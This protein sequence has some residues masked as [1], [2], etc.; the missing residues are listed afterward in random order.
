MWRIR[1]WSRTFEVSQSKRC[2]EAIKWVPIPNKQ[3]GDGYTELMDHPN[4]AAH[5]GAW[6][7]I[8]QL[9]SKCR[10]R[11]TLA[12]DEGHAHDVQSIARITRIRPEVLEESIPRFLK[13]RWLEEVSRSA[14]GEV[15]ECSPSTGQDR[16]GQDITT[17]PAGSPV[18]FSE[19]FNPDAWNHA[20]AMAKA[21][22]NRIWPKRE[23]VLD[24]GDYELVGKAAYLA[25]T[26]LSEAWFM[27]ALDGID[28]PSVRNRVAV[29]KSR[30]WKKPK[31][32][33]FDLNGL[34]DRTKIPKQNTTPISTEVNNADQT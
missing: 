17:G 14:L 8:V 29:F 22:R 31:E 30:L 1:E 32:M 13:I 34:L 15:S 10:P 27:D 2:P 12:R 18:G 16:T 4:G 28:A 11:G 3:D 6:T 25:V 20:V 23:R 5:F 33:G 19:E 7:A 21:A 26:C 24:P 9:A